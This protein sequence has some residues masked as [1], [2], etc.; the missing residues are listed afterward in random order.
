MP[1]L[2]DL[3]MPQLVD[4]YYDDAGRVAPPCKDHFGFERRALSGRRGL[5]ALEHLLVGEGS[6]TS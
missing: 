3:A 4:S 1:Q 2:V 5:Q 6:E